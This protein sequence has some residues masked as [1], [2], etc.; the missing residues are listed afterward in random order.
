MIA[1]D[2]T[3]ASPNSDG[4]QPNGRLVVIHST[5]SGVSLNPGELPGT[6]AWFMRADTKVSSHWVIGR[7]GT[8][9]RVIPD[10]RIA[11][12]AGEHNVRGWGIELEQGVYG[13]GFT[14]LQIQALIDVAR[15]Y[16]QDF[17]VPAVHTLD[18]NAAGFIGHAETVQGK[19]VGKSDPGPLFPWDLFIGALQTAAPPAPSELELRLGAIKAMADKY[20]FEYIGPNPIGQHVVRL[21]EK[22]G[23]IAQPESY[24]AIDP[25]RR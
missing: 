3:S 1:P 25:A 13:D 18:S 9:V 24:I 22:D 6:L 19:R 2:R 15:G 7:D 21:R 20:D 14:P 12:H 17:G 23:S 4:G 5:R 8:K 16:V 11:W 10:N